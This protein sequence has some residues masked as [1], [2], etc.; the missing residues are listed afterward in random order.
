ME[1]LFQMLLKV[2]V[3]LLPFTSGEFELERKNEEKEYD[4]V[5]FSVLQKNCELFLLQ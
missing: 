2:E 1:L 5:S 3:H 4:L